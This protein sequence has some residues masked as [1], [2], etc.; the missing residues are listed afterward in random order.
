MAFEMLGGAH[1][2]ATTLPGEYA[3]ASDDGPHTRLAHLPATAHAFF[4]RALAIDRERR[5]ASA[6]AFMAELERSVRG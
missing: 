5:P 3:P 6:A 2:F 1:P 4:A